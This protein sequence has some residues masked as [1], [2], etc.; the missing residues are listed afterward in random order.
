[1]NLKVIHINNSDF[2]FSQ[3]KK[4]IKS[5]EYK[6]LHRSSAI[7]NVA[8]K[9]ADVI[10]EQA[11][12]HYLNEKKRGYEEGII[13]SKVDQ[14]EQMLKIVGRS[15]SYLSEIENELSEVLMSAVN[16]IIDGFDDKELTVG[17]IRSGL[18]HVRNE[19]QVTVRIPPG[20][21]THV[22]GKINEILADYKGIGFINPVSDPRLD[23]GSCILE[24]RIGVVDASV[25]IQLAALSQRFERVSSDV[26]GSVANGDVTEDIS[27]I[28]DRDDGGNT[29]YSGT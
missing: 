8:K 14:S 18:Q 10:I 5:S 24:S 11:E 12:K 29:E 19:R 15:I 3:G 28:E 2:A 6:T 26:S 13:E 9:R 22:K 21:F 1:M 7:I 20:H 16:K 4:Y 17:L 27:S 25:D 23:A